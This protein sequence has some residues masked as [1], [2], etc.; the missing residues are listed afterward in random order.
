[1][2]N[3]VFLVFCVFLAGRHVSL[4]ERGHA[5]DVAKRDQDLLQH[6]GSCMDLLYRDGGGIQEK[7]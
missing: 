1:M 5:L 3:F 2:M 7:I 4:T 6:D